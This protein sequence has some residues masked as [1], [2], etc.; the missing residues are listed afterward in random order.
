MTEEDA[1][2]RLIAKIRDY[3][4]DRASNVT[5]GAETPHLAALLLEK[6]GR[7]MVDAAAELFDGRAMMDRIQ[8]VVDEEV[9]R[10]D[11]DWKANAHR[12]WAGRPADITTGRAD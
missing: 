7:G 9:T 11:P 2:E 10:T 12:R 4:R 6:Y 1:A 8:A 3:A 5:R